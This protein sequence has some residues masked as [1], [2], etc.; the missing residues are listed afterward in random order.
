[1]LGTMLSAISNTNS[2][3]RRKESILRADTPVYVLGE[4]REGGLI[5]KPASG[6][7]NKTF[8][9]SHKSEEERTKSLTS[10]T[11]WLLG[12][13]IF[14]FV[15]AAVFAYFGVKVGPSRSRARRRSRSPLER[16]A[17]PFQRGIERRVV[18]GE[19]ETHD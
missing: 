11:R 19:A 9:I 16:A 3:Y 12:I 8:V 18:L 6:S 4:V 7:K 15:L 14:L 17:E 2:T 13:A 1:M 5:G 10:T